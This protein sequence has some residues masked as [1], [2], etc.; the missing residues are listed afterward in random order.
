MKIWMKV[1]YYNYYNKRRGV[2]LYGRSLDFI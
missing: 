1:I 2:T